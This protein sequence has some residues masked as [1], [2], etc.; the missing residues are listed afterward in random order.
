VFDFIELDPLYRWHCY[1]ASGTISD[2]TGAFEGAQGVLQVEGF[3]R[4]AP[5]IQDAWAVGLGTLFLQE[6]VPTPPKG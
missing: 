2:G 1:S 5:P 3:T 4:I 6:I